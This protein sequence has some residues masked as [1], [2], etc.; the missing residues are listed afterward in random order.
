MNVGASILFVFEDKKWIEKVL[1]GGLI[2]LATMVLGFTIIGTVG[3]SAC[4]SAMP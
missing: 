3:G 4:C 2:V 1:I